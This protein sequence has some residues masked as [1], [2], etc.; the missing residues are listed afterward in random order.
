MKI[1]VIIPSFTGPYGAERLVLNLC[2]ELIDMGNEVT[3]FT[4]RYEHLCDAMVHPQLEIIETGHFTL[5]DWDLTK[6]VEHYSVARIYKRLTNDFDIINIHNYPTPLAA[7]LAK[8]LKRVNRPIVYQC[9]EPPRFIYDL[10]GET[11]R[12]FNFLKRFPMTISK[13]FFKKADQ[14]S[15][16]YVDEIVTISRFMQHVIKETY[17]RDSIFIMPGIET[18][19]LNLGVN[20][21]EVRQKFSSDGD[22][23]ALTCNKLHPRKRIDIL[24]RS[25]PYIVEKHKDFKV[26]ITG[27]GIEKKKLQ[28]LIND[29]DLQPYVKLVGFIP[30]EELPKYYAACDV[31][32]FTAI[33]EPQIGSPAEAL[34]SGKPVI[35]PNDGGP[36]E[37]IVEG[38]TGLL[39][40]PLDSQDLAEKII[41]CMENRSALLGMA[42]S[43]RRW[44]EQNMTWQKMA[45]ETYE[46]F[47]SVTKK[48]E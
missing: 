40:K 44:V 35:A 47:K 3:L 6:L 48:D 15:I 7:A 38:K 26:I 39:F 25:V 4:P 33:R 24:I 45:R 20:G 21:N 18:K 23:I 43:C 41:W 9:N 12:R 22:F 16:G 32:I 30:E 37:T 8:K 1:A 13:G 27:D 10:A 29:L 2:Y 31:F 11:Y 34:A 46:V 17:N 19:R 5:G 28:S 42:K 36:A 14:W